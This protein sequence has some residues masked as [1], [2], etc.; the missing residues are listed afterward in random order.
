MYQKNYGICSSIRQCA[1]N[2]NNPK[3]FYLAYLSS[4]KIIVTL[5]PKKSRKK[6]D[7]KNQKE[8]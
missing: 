7:R 2:V 6:L 5:N 1:A 4:G 8:N 3:T